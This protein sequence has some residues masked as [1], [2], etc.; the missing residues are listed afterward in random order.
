MSKK[1]MSERQYAAHSGM[2]RGAVQKAKQS[3]RLVVHRDGSIDAAASDRRREAVT[4]PSQQRGPGNSLLSKE[5][6]GEIL[7]MVGAQSA[8]ALRSMPARYV[9]MDEVD[10]YPASTDEEGDPVALAEART[11]TFGHRRKVFMVK[12]ARR[13]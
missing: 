9:F 6:P 3:G 1:G 12:V 4:D 2:S 11:V 7:V 10:G 5:F 13:V 8:A